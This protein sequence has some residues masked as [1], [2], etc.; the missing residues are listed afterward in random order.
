MPNE[1]RKGAGRREID[2][3]VQLVAAARAEA[4]ESKDITLDHIK[5]CADNYVALKGSV[6]VLLPIADDIRTI[7]R[8]GAWVGGFL[9]FLVPVF[10]IYRA[11]H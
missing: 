5:E 9:V 3:V 7:K 2:M 8:L 6:D 11:L 10:E 4:K 1:R